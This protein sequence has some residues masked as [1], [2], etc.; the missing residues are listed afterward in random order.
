M[1]SP[2]PAGPARSA[3]PARPAKAS[4]AA[5]IGLGGFACLL[6]LSVAAL[7]WVPWWAV[8]V[9]VVVWVVLFAVAARSFVPAPRRV[10]WL[11]VAGLALWA[12]VVVG[13]G[14]AF[15]WT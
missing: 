14:L 4:A 15:G 6:F 7:M 9:L 8:V 2:S 12:V 1:S 3:R 10:L 13:G 5:F 11:A